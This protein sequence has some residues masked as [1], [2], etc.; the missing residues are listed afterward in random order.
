MAVIGPGRFD[1]GHGTR[2]RA[3]IA[4]LQGGGEFC[5]GAQLSNVIPGRGAAANPEAMNTGIAGEASMT[6]PCFP[7]TCSWVPG[8]PL[9]G[10]PE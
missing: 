1:E 10:I 9:R 6:T 5:Y 3:P 8:L 4:A 2:E 7:A